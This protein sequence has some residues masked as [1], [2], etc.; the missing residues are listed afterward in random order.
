V[1]ASLGGEAFIAWCSSRHRT[2]R[3]SVESGWDV[4]VDKRKA[5]DQHIGERVLGPRVSAIYMIEVIEHV[6]EHQD[7]F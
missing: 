1:R 5:I 7:S 4:R 2:L 3:R 6:Q